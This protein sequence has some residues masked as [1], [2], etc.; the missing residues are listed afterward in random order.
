MNTVLNIAK[1]ILVTTMSYHILPKVSEATSLIVPKQ[2]S[3]NALYKN[4][5]FHVSGLCHLV[6]VV[7]LNFD[8]KTK[9]IFADQK[10]YRLIVYLFRNM[11]L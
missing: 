7:S 1:N 4:E 8:I 5:N 6:K 10:L 11:L 3:N 9:D 2:I